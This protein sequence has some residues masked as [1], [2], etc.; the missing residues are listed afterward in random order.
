MDS[1][2]VDVGM[3]VDEV[4]QALLASAAQPLSALGRNSGEAASGGR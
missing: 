4:Q 2:V 1:K 3:D